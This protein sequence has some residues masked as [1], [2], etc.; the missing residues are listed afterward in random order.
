ME[1]NVSTD[2][3]G[4]SQ[5]PCEGERTGYTFHQTY[6]FLPD[7]SVIDI[8]KNGDPIYPEYVLSDSADLNYIQRSVLN[9]VVASEKESN[10]NNFEKRI[11]ETDGKGTSVVM[12]VFFY[13][14]MLCIRP[15]NMDHRVAEFRY[16]VF[17]VS[18]RNFKRGIVEGT[19]IL[20]VVDS[21]LTMLFP[22]FKADNHDSWTSASVEVFK[23]LKKIG[24]VGYWATLI[25]T[26]RTTVLSEKVIK[27][28]L[29]PDLD[30]TFRILDI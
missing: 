17:G 19:K 12:P 18:A 23:A 30:I 6:S 16:S 26:V 20:P 25:S 22:D 13:D 8:S 2:F 10:Y 29:F 21:T 27:T 4:S 9:I 7:G 15:A 28:D 11:R 24:I 3:F 1:N 14:E 5:S